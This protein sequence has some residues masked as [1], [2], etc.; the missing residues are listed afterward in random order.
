M[1]VSKFSEAQIAFVSGKAENGSLSAE[2]YRMA[3][4]SE[5]TFYDWRRKY[6][7]LFD[8]SD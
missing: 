2:G 6:A 8:T 4:I 5:M 3:G 1:R 7:G